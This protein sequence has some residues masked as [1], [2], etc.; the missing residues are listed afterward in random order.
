MYYQHNQTQN[1]SVHTCACGQN[2]YYHYI[3]LVSHTCTYEIGMSISNKLLIYAPKQ[4]TGICMTPL[5]GL[6]ENK[7]QESHAN[8]I[9]LPA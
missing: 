1:S 6:F 7:Y 9:T 5:Q 2:K 8:H 4:Y 3:I